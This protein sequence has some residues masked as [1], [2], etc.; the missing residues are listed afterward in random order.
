MRYSRE[1]IR[2]R[3]LAL[4]KTTVLLLIGFLVGTGTANLLLGPR[5]D[6]LHLERDQ[7][8]IRV[9]DLEETVRKQTETARR[10]TK[11]VKINVVLLNKSEQFPNLDLE[12]Q[13]RTLLRPLLGKTVEEMSLPLIWNLL[14]GRIVEV[15]GARFKLELKALLLAP[16]TEAHLR[17]ATLEEK[18][19]S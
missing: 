3:W 10:G 17:I 11:V 16:T 6:A 5:I 4:R 13:A 18:L 15:R 19:M 8:E 1:L 9:A 14:D 7:L 12:E 2:E